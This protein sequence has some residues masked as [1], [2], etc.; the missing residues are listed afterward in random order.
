MSDRDLYLAC[1][2]QWAAMYVEGHWTLERFE[3]HADRMREALCPVWPKG[4]AELGRRGY[5]R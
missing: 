2:P 3:A 1:L 4:L 5:S